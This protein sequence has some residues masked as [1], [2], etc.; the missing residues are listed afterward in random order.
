MLNGRWIRNGGAKG[1]TMTATSSEVKTSGAYD[2]LAMYINRRQR[3]HVKPF[4][5]TKDVATKRWK[6]L[7][8][9]LFLFLFCL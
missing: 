1:S 6:S 8:V 7:S 5:W 3:D 2:C 4:I 9:T